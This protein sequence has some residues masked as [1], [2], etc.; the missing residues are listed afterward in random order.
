MALCPSWRAFVLSASPLCLAPAAIIRY[1]KPSDAD[2]YVPEVYYT[3]KNEYGK[4]V[5]SS[6]APSFPSDY[7]MVQLTATTKKDG[8]GGGGGGGGGAA[9]AA[10][11]AFPIENRDGMGELQ[12]ILEFSKY[13]QLPGSLLSKLSNFHVLYFLST[14]C[15][16]SLK[17]D[18][19]DGL[20]KAIATGKEGAVDA[21][22]TMSP[23]WA[24]L[25][26]IMAEQLTD[27]GTGGGGGG[28][29]ASSSGG[30]SG[31]GGGGGGFGGSWACTACTFINDGAGSTC[32]C[33]NTPR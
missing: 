7:L 29:G 3:H 5:K 1:V 32:A 8:G 28:G 2:L 30:G 23:K 14:S 6:A 11:G 27:A 12:N 16:V 24:T 19:L 31:G 15:P 13:C 4:E 22:A 9:A 25:L 10:A 21:W 26:Y 33:C 18:D 17:G 20:L